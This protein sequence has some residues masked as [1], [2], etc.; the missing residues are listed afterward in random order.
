MYGIEIFTKRDYHSVDMAD[1][2]FDTLNREKSA[3]PY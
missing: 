3:T 1:G 2:S